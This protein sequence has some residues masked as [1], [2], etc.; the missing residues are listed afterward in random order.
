VPTDRRLRRSGFPR[1]TRSRR[2]DARAQILE[3]ANQHRLAQDS[4]RKPYAARHINEAVCTVRRNR[5]V[6]PAVLEAAGFRP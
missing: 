5:L 4:P 3:A 1:S 2:L 6:K